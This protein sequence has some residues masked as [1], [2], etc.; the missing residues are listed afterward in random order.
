V[1][2]VAVGLVGTG[3]GLWVLA[4]AGSA[5]PSSAVATVWLLAGFD[6]VA[7]AVHEAG[8]ALVIHGGGRRVGRA[9]FGF[10]WG[11]VS[12]FVDATDA[13]FL[14]RRLR[15]AQAAAGPA[16]TL[17]LGGVLGL[18]ATV[19][20]P[21]AT[22]TVLAQL[23]LLCA[24]EVVV[25]LSPLL[26]LDGYW[27][28]ADLVDPPDLA[29]RARD[30]ARHPRRQ[31]RLAAYAVASVLFGDALIVLAGIAGV[32]EFGPLVVD[33]VRSGPAGIAGVVVFLGPLA[34][35]LVVGAAHL[36]ASRRR[37]SPDRTIVD[38]GR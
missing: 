10:Y 16:A 3:A 13:F 19:M 14:P 23:T 35:G 26:K 8:H 28:L 29:E 25:N 2:V 22:A 30:A 32:E 24:L 20:A 34:A 31:P 36:I 21:S 6:L 15:I 33:A 1:V 27:I 17:A 18:A 9:G 5:P 4:G 11:S 7:V 37:P 12:F 38:E